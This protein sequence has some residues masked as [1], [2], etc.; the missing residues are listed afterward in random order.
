MNDRRINKQYHITIKGHDMCPLPGE[1]ELCFYCYEFGANGGNPHTHIGVK[2]VD[3]INKRDLVSYLRGYCDGEP[4]VKPHRQ[5]NTIVGYHY[6]CGDKQACE[7]EP[8]W[9]VGTVNKRSLLKSKGNILETRTMLDGDLKTLVDD[10]TVS[11]WRLRSLQA[12]QRTYRTLR[13]CRVL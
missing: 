1:L 9:I 11:V 8:A 4:D 2:F 6:G 13:T 10:G 3:G 12:I 7:P 5:W